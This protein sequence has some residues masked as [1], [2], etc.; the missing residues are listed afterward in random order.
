MADHLSDWERDLLKQ[1]REA[2]IEAEVERRVAAKLGEAAVEAKR[3]ALPRRS[4]MDARAIARFLEANGQ[5]AF[6]ALPR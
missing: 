3:K 1:R 4:E 5:E 6:E 2:E